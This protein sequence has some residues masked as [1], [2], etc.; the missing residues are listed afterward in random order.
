MSSSVTINGK[1]YVGN[2]V[3]IR[4]KKVFIDGKEQ[5]ST[6]DANPVDVIVKGVLEHLDAE[7]SVTC[8]EV[9]GNVSAGGSVECGDVG[10]IVQAGGSVHCGKV[11]GM[12][13]AG[14]SVH[15]R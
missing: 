6:G 10:G 8:E 12:I 2:N 15:H 14:G 5:G 11:G 1:T 3:T 13:Q 7:G 9:Q 4:G